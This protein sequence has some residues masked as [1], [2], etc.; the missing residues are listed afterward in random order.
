MQNIIHIHVKQFGIICTAV[1]LLAPDWHEVKW[2]RYR[3][4]AN[5]RSMQFSVGLPQPAYTFVR[6]M[7]SP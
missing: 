5:Q 6:D 2:L 7:C 4:G 3:N 1:P